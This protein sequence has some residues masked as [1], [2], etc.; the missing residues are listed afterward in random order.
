M[1]HTHH[2]FQFLLNPIPNPNPNTHRFFQ[3]LRLNVDD[4]PPFLW[5]YPT[6]ITL[7]VGAAGPRELLAPTPPFDSPSSSSQ[8]DEE[9]TPALNFEIARCTAVRTLFGRPPDPSLASP[10]LASP[11]TMSNASICVCMALIH[12]RRT[13][14][15]G[16]E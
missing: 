10:P 4:P 11:G 2:F 13:A 16:A 9:L 8:E 15:D 3:F 1:S 6:R 7:P 12:L 5:M 14:R